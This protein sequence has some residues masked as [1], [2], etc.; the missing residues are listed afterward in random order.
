MVLL[1]GQYKPILVS[2]ICFV[3]TSFR[4]QKVAVIKVGFGEYVYIGV[5]RVV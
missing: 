1:F 4:F 2:C 3:V 5:L